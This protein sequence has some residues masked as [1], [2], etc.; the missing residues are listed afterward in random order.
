MTD[1]SNKNRNKNPARSEIVRAS[2]SQPAQNRLLHRTKKMSE[3]RQE[4]LMWVN[5]LLQLNY[6]KI[7]QFGS[8]AWRVL[9]VWA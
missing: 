2:S 1:K 8:G 5:D 4:L 7:E 9:P 6:T 3:S